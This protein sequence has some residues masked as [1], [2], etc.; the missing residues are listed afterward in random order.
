MVKAVMAATVPTGAC[1]QVDPSGGHIGRQRG[2]GVGE[3]QDRVR[4][5]AARDT[6]RGVA[7]DQLLGSVDQR[8]AEP[9]V[10]QHGFG[11]ARLGESARELWRR[12]DPVC[13]A[14]AGASVVV[15]EEEGAAA[16][17]VGIFHMEGRGHLSP[18]WSDAVMDEPDAA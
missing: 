8:G 13:G 18:C 9:G 6:G 11:D 7:G 2:Q 16:W 1:D 12:G 15:D 10:E 4:N 14:D 5:R 17:V 3:E